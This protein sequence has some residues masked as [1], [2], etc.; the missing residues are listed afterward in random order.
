MR[1]DGSPTL[2]IPKGG[3]RGKAGRLVSSHG[4]EPVRLTGGRQGSCAGG[5]SEMD[6]GPKLEG[7]GKQC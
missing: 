6:R 5:G 7:R 2:P 3:E 4:Q 1:E